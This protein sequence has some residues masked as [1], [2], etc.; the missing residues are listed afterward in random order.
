MTRAIRLFLSLLLVCLSL[1]AFSGCDKTVLTPPLDGKDGSRPVSRTPLEEARA[2]MAA[3]DYGRVEVLAQRET[4]R[5]GISGKD[6]AEF[7]QL[8]A[9]AALRNKHPN[10]TLTALDQWRM[11][12]P[13]V[14]AKREWQDLWCQAMADISPWT[15]KTRA[16]ALYQDASRS[17]YARSMAGIFLAVRQWEE[18]ALGETMPVLEN[19]YATA[20]DKSLRA[21]LETRLALQLY[22][23]N[24][25]AVSLVGGTVTPENQG[26][27]PYSIILV[28]QL[29]R[30]TLNAATRAEAL[31]ALDRLAKTITLA[32]PSLF[33]GLPAATT[34]TA[35]SSGPITGKP[36]V[37]ALPLSGGLGNM[38]AKIVAGAEVACREFAA[39]GVQVSLVVIDT[40]QPDWIARVD[41]L[42]KEAAIIG[43]PLRTAAYSAARAQGLTSRRALFTFMPGLEP[44]EEGT[45][46]WRF[47][48]SSDDQVET[49]LRFSGNLGI[50]GYAVFY[51]EEAYGNRMSSAFTNKAQSMGAAV[52]TAS[53]TPDQPTSWLRSVGNLL[54]ANKNSEHARGATFQAVFLPDTWKNMDVIVPNIF[55]YNET[56]QLLMGTSLWEQGISSG[57]FVSPQYYGLAIFPGA[58]NAGLLTPAGERLQS[59]LLS[60]GKGQADYWAGIGSDFARLSASMNV[61]S[62]WSASG[63]NA[64]LQSQNMDWSMAPIRWDAFGKA[65]Q[66][67][68]LFTP[69]EGGFAPVNEAEFRKAFSAAWK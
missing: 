23:A 60:S 27:Y 65:R 57:G 6:L 52:H 24:T 10:V 69:V 51:P 13:N 67:L 62:G 7:S 16:E 31:A 22:T 32:E 50:K 5:A 26:Q 55:Y 48:P 9:T 44:G 17:A 30:Q 25:A 42:P 19:L 2:A 37:L 34:A 20:P 29:R 15:A 21:M 45:T 28:D 66:E 41:A 38:S 1:V 47:F 40:D 11:A 64:A 18:G 35:V 3:G 54:A 63:V 56:R 39:S 4:A 14:D 49:L 58:W 12:D 59:G 68:F 33:K 43:G 61:S 46:A 53:Y 36:V 8:Y